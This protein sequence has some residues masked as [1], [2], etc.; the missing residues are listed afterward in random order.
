MRQRPETTFVFNP[1][2]TA[3]LT[4]AKVGPGFVMSTSTSTRQ[5][6]ICCSGSGLL[7]QMDRSKALRYNNFGTIQKFFW[8]H[9]V[10]RSG[11]QKAIT[12]DNGTQFDA[13]TFKTFCN[14]I[15]TKYT[16]HQ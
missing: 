7:L 6:E 10:C 13:E 16:S 1:V 2:N 4:I 12:V 9:I 8:Q 5:L 3:Y 14:Q 15:G 11:V